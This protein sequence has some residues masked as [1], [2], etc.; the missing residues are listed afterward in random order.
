[1][2]ELIQEVGLNKPLHRQAQTII[3]EIDTISLAKV[4]TILAGSKTIMNRIRKYNQLENNVDLFYAGIDNEIYHYDGIV[5]YQSPIV[6]GR[7]EFPKRPELFVKAMKRLPGI[8]G[9]IIGQGGRTED[10]KKIDRL[11]TYIADKGLDI[12]DETVWKRISNGAFQPEEIELLKRSQKLN[13]KSNVI[14]TGRVSKQ[15]LFKEYANSLCV[16]CPAYE[17]DYG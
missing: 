16:I 14:F 17:E 1:M 8:T 2:S 4:S 15:Q 3:R 5:S 13:L 11:L 9:R 7:H 12:P 10:L 6:V